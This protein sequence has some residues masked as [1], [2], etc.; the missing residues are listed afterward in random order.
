MMK[1]LWPFVLMKAQANKDSLKLTLIRQ[2]TD[3]YSVK[4]EAKQ[5]PGKSPI[6]E[7]WGLWDYSLGGP[8]SYGDTKA[9]GTL[10]CKTSMG[11]EEQN[12]IKKVLGENL[13]IMY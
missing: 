1:W 12:Q 3:K 2:F 9:I 7:N 5:F 8:S 6:W 11:H 4:Y 10:E 13:P